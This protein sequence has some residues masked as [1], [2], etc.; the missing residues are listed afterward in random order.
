MQIYGEGEKELFLQHRPIFP[1][2]ASHSNDA[3]L[4]KPCWQLLQRPPAFLQPLLKGRWGLQ[5]HTSAGSACECAISYPDVPCL[6]TPAL[7]CGIGHAQS[8]HSLKVAASP[9][10]IESSH[11]LLSF[12]G[13][14]KRDARGNLSLLSWTKTHSNTALSSPTV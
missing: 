8:L 13:S 3:I 7:S 11:P 9:R 12:S 6:L 4:A 2:P 5:H 10:K 1:L 14:Q